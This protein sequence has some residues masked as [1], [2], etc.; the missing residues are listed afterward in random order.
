MSFRRDQPD[1]MLTAAD[2][3]AI[4]D[5][6]AAILHARQYPGRDLAAEIEAYLAEHQPSTVPEIAFGVTARES[7]VRSLLNADDRFQRAVSA[8]GRSP[9][10]KCWQLAA[11]ADPT[12]PRPRRSDPGS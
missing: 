6:V 2:I 8:P 9:R 4:A 10:A 5:R 12:Q 7:T 1:L 3:D 11:R